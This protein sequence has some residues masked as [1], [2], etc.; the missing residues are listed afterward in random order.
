MGRLET[1]SNDILAVLLVNRND[2]LS[3]WGRPFDHGVQP[4]P[5]SKLR[6]FRQCADGA[7]Q[8]CDQSANACDDV[9]DLRR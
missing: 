4:W 7:P 3:A 5:R 6:P 8:A 2:A 9:V 1:V